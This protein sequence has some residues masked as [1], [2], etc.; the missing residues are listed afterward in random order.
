MN[1][2]PNNVKIEILARKLAIWNN[3][4][5]DASADEKLARILEDKDLSKAAQARMKQALKAI[6]AINGMIAGVNGSNPA[7][8]PQ[9][10]TELNDVSQE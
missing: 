1:D 5:F 10:P 2:I 4:L 9:E 6:E 3:T 8:T 7:E